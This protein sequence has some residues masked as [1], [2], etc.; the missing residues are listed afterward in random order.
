GADAGG[1][2]AVHVPAQRPCHVLRAG[3]D[4][5]RGGGVLP[6]AGGAVPGSGGPAAD[7]RDHA[8]VRGDSP[9]AGDG[10]L[11]VGQY[12]GGGAGLMMLTHDDIPRHPWLATMERAAQAF[13]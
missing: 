4:D 13:V 12:A 3:G 1:G 5:L 10:D 9:V 6:R 2:V 8:H 11:W 7:D